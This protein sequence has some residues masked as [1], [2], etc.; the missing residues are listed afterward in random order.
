MGVIDDDDP[1]LAM[2]EHSKTKTE[3]P[4]KAGV[5]PWGVYGPKRANTGH[6]AFQDKRISIE[7][8]GERKAEELRA[9]VEEPEYPMQDD[10][11]SDFDA[12]SQRSDASSGSAGSALAMI[13]SL[14][15]GGVLHR[16]S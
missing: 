1:T 13:H 8:E 5:N 15:A 10:D 12:S 6:V 11:E 2:L 14:T 3:P 7:P 16:N 4:A 9:D